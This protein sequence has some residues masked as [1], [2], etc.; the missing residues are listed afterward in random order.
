MISAQTVANLFCQTEIQEFLILDCRFDY[1]YK[2][3]C[4]SSHTFINKLLEGHIKG[5]INIL[6]QEVLEKILF[7]HKDLLYNPCF[8]EDL[9]K[10]CLSTLSKAESYNNAEARSLNSE[11]PII[12]F[13]CEFSQKRGPRAFRAL[14]SKDRDLN[15]NNWP[16]LFYNDAYV[17][18]G[19]YSDFYSQ[20]PVRDF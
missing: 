6:S 9:K 1:E 12:I 11:L 4:Y 14:R 10:D 19:G 5:A 17:L 2:G 8:I 15:I 18:D 13:H 3:N 20:F 7:T 16:N